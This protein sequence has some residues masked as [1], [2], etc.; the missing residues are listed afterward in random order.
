V[1]LLIAVV[2]GFITTVLRAIV[3]GRQLRP[4][5]LRFGWLVFIAVLPQILL[6]Q[7]PAVGGEVPDAL[8]SIILVASQTTLLGFVLTN[9]AQPGVWMLGIGLTANFLAIITNGGWMPISPETVHRILPSLPIEYPLVGHRLGLSKDWVF[10]SG[11][12][13]FFRLADR[14]TTPDWI[15]HKVAFSIGDILIALG[16]ILLLWSLSSKNNWRRYDTANES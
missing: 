3:T 4:I 5:S 11:D 14:F 1:I 6:F 9:L 13:T 10:P 7:V 8:A 12:I 16:A 2:I 15:S